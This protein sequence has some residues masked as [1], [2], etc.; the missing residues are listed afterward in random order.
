MADGAIS[1]I[2]L[3]AKSW[4]GLWKEK[5]K[6]MHWLRLWLR[7]KRR[8]RYKCRKWSLGNFKCI[9]ICIL[10]QTGRIILYTFLEYC[11]KQLILYFMVELKIVQC[12]TLLWISSG[13]E[14]LSHLDLVWFLSNMFCR[15]KL[16]WF[17]LTHISVIHHYIFQSS[18]FFK[19]FWTDL[20]K[21]WL[22]F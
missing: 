12:N 17:P 19:G 11:L 22:E 10:N 5:R 16:L 21:Y 9:F 18:V 1:E 13:T 15:I 7:S 3:C 8:G 6:S 20:L 2:R 4:P 14:S